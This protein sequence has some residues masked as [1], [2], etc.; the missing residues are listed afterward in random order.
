MNKYLLMSSMAAMVIL[1]LWLSRMPNA[2]R[3]LKA[4]LF[5]TFAFNILWAAL[6][7]G[8]FLFL[9]KDPQAILPLPVENL[10]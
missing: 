1:P 8:W 3:G 10:P 9:M 6:V 5:S 2:T 4:T 7:L